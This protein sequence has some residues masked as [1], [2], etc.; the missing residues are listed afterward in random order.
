MKITKTLLCVQNF[1]LIS[2]AV[3]N[4][5][6]LLSSA[7]GKRDIWSRTKVI[8]VP[9]SICIYGGKTRESD[10]LQKY[11]AQ[12]CVP[13]QKCVIAYLPFREGKAAVAVLKQNFISMQLLSI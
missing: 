12:A 8:D 4:I 3:L 2:N 11:L 10:I 13:G 9:L 5:L 7:E 6:E 1:S